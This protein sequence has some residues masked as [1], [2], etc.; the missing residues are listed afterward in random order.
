MSQYLV[1]C[2]YQLEVVQGG[3]SV[4]EEHEQSAE[5]MKEELNFIKHIQSYDPF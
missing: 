3:D 2:V 5:E 1:V 4:L